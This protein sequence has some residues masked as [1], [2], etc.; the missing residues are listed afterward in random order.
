[1]EISSG[2]LLPDQGIPL[3][4]SRQELGRTEPMKLWKEKRKLGWALC[5]PRRDHHHHP[6]RSA[7][8]KLNRWT[9]PCR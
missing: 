4:K 3:L 2:E 6:N 9:P 7:P 8:T 5:A 1:M